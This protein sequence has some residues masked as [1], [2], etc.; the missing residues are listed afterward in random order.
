MTDISNAP[1]DEAFSGKLTGTRR[2]F[3]RG[4]AAAGASTAAAAALGRAGTID[5]SLIHI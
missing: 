2:N 5:L 3:I 1:A 4:V